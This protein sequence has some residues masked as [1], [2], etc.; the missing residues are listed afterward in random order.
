M[1]HLWLIGMMGSGK[2]AVGNRI[3]SATGVQFVDTDAMVVAHV[4]RPVAEIFASEGEEAFRS[5]E[6]DAVQRASGGARSVIA[7]GGGVVLRREN[8]ETMRATG[9][10]LYLTATPETLLRRIGS[11][12]ARPL[13]AGKD[14]QAVLAGLLAHRRSLYDSAR[15][16][17]IDTD[18]LTLDE[19]AGR[20]SAAWN[21][22]SSAPNRKF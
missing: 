19:V 2:T 16:I 8:V 1:R 6:T 10:V 13:L 17:V 3:S 18:G 21:E 11:D 22:Y 5:Y 14:A 12:T 7:T 9:M 15:H 20:A 4:G